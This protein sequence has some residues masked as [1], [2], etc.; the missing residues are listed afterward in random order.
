MH[1]LFEPILAYQ[2]P[3]RPLGSD[4]LNFPLVVDKMADGHPWPKPYKLIEKLVRHW[5]DP[6]E[7]VLDPF[8]GSGTTGVACRQLDR[9]FIGI[10]I[11]E[12]YFEIARKRLEMPVQKELI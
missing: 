12:E 2:R 6:G 11:N 7:V 1:I 4:L 9:K 5:S 8:M 3:L 10:E